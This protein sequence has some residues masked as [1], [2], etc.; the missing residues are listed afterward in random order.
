MH[1]GCKFSIPRRDSRKCFRPHLAAVRFCQRVLPATPHSEGDFGSLLGVRSCFYSR[2]W[3]LYCSPTSPKESS[4]RLREVLAQTG[5][6]HEVE[7]S[8]GRSSLPSVSSL[9][10]L[11]FLGR[12]LGRLRKGCRLRPRVPALQRHIQIYVYVYNIYIYIYI[13]LCLG[14]KRRLRAA[15][16][17]DGKL[18]RGAWVQSTLSAQLCHIILCHLIS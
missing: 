16:D 12:P 14:R 7:T 9:P 13:C 17:E 5:H 2:T 8:L 11:P 15:D 6:G 10:P 3:A 18:R 1:R 4:S